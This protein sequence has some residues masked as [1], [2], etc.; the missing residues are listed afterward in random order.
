MRV[1]R[2]FRLCLFLICATQ[3]VLTPAVVPDD[4]LLGPNH[5]GKLTVGMPESA[6]YKAW[7]P[8]LTRKTVT[9]PEGIETPAVEIFLRKDRKTPSLVVILNAGTIYGI[10]VQDSRFKTAEGIGV[11]SSIA[12][13][14][15]TKLHFELNR[16]EGEKL[17]C[18]ELGMGFFVKIDSDTDSRLSGHEADPLAFIP[19]GV[20]IEGIWI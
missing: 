3:K 11:G 14:R 18:A 13:L 8:E 7:A 2:G 10:Q 20:K 1:L 6:I 5:A 4:L 15:K 17:I 9:Y 12:D 16:E 19:P